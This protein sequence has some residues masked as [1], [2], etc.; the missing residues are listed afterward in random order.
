[1]G[2]KFFRQIGIAYAVSSQLVALYYWVIW[3][4]Q[5]HNILSAIF[6]G[7]LYGEFR[8]L[9]WPLYVIDGILHG[10]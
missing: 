4:T 7:F 8:G 6:L 2:D 10:F 5:S 3:G 1:M 9:A